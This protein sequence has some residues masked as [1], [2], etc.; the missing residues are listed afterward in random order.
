M[1]G[2]EN[3]DCGEGVRVRS[4]KKKKHSLPR[5]RLGHA[6]IR[7][8]RLDGVEGSSD[9]RASEREREENREGEVPGGVGGEKEENVGA[10]A[11]IFGQNLHLEGLHVH[12]WLQALSTW[13]K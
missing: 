9:G 13:I 3:G 4:K 2:M 11:R 6:D 1:E 7:R 12:E 8:G 10:V 5:G